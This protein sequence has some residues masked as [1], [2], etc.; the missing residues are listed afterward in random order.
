M[1]GILITPTHRTTGCIFSKCRKAREK[2]TDELRKKSHTRG[3]GH[4]QLHLL[5]QV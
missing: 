4:C 5:R 3:E 1:F 2:G